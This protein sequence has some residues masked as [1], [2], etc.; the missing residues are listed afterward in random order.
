MERY[1]GI[2]GLAVIIG[3]AYLASLDRKA[4]KPRVIVWGLILQF[5]FALF[6]MKVPIGIAILSWVADVPPVS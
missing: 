3:I 1:I 5:I 6:V 2:V 4:I